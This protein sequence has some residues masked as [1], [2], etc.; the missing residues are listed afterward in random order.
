VCR[1]TKRLIWKRIKNK[2]SQN[3][4][5][6]QKSPPPPLAPLPKDAEERVTRLV[7]EAMFPLSL[8]LDL[9][10]KYKDKYSFHFH[11]T[12]GKCMGQFV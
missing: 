1:T 7:L 2:H 12:R 8:S 11:I 9:S 4:V 3:S 10:E 5:Y 6:L